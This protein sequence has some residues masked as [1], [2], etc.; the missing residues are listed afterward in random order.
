MDFHMG[1][2]YKI[3][4]PAFAADPVLQGLPGRSG[5]SGR[6][7]VVETGRLRSGLFLPDA[8]FRNL[9]RRHSPGCKDR[10]GHHD[11]PRPL[12]RDR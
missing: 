4:P 2:P 12:H 9:R 10:P 6:A 7:L 1:I 8:D 3:L 11:R 5:L